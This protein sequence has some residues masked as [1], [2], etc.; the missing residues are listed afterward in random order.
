MKHYMSQESNRVQPTLTESTTHLTTVVTVLS[1]LLGIVVIWAVLATIRPKCLTTLKNKLIL[2]FTSFNKKPAL[3]P[4]LIELGSTNESDP[5]P[6]LETDQC[7]IDQELKRRHARHR[8]KSFCPYK[9]TLDQMKAQIKTEAYSD[10]CR[11]LRQAKLEVQAEIEEAE[12]KKQATK[13]AKVEVEAKASA[14]TF[15]ES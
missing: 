6:S 7:L 3:P 11:L 2:F 5:T 8:N 1:V 15:E 4:N 14:P 9:R 12:A 13:E 10:L